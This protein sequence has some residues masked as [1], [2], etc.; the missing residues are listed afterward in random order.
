MLNKGSVLFSGESKK[1][2]FPAVARVARK[3][4]TV[5]WTIID[6]ERLFSAV[7]NEKRNCISCDDAEINAHFHPRKI[8]LTHTDKEKEDQ[9]YSPVNISFDLQCFSFT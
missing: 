5:H 6:S 2:R 4:L 9:A 7:I 1:V 8:N 3:H